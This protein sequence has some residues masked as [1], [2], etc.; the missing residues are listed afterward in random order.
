MV[1]SENVF[2]VCRLQISGSDYNSNGYADIELFH[3]EINAINQ[4]NKWKSDTLQQLKSWGKNFEIFS[5]TDNKYHLSWDCDLE[6]IIIT[7]R[8]EV[9]R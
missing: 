4:F 8:V 6:M 3:D 2:V 1:G 5:D 9:I 7:I